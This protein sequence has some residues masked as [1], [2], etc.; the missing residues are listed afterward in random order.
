VF[1]FS[2]MAPPVM[3]LFAIPVYALWAWFHTGL[4]GWLGQVN[5]RTYMEFEAFQALLY[6]DSIQRWLGEVKIAANPS[7]NRYVLS[8]TLP[9]RLTLSSFRIRLHDINN[10]EV[11]TSGVTIDPSMQPDFRRLTAIVRRTPRRRLAISK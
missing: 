10:A 4:L 11:D 6:D 3:I 9:D 8:G 2:F 7:E 1:G 5:T